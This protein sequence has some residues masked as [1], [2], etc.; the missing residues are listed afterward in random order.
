MIFAGLHIGHDANAT[1]FVDGKLAVSVEAERVLGEKHVIGIDAALVALRAA[2]AH[3]GISSDDIQ[4]ICL[5]DERIPPLSVEERYPEVKKRTHSPPFVIP[6]EAE[7]GGDGGVV[8]RIKNELGGIDVFVCCH[9]VA[10]AASALYMAGYDACDVF[11]YDGYGSCGASMGLRYAASGLA[12][13]EAF[14][15]R[16]MVGFKYSQ[17]GYF[18]DGIRKSGRIGD[19]NPAFVADY[20]DFAGKIMGAH[21]YGVARPDLVADFLD[22]FTSRDGDAYEKAVHGREASSPPIASLAPGNAYQNLCTDGLKIAERASFDV[23]AAMQEA[24]TAAAE[25]AVSELTRA[26]ASRRLVMAGG[27]AL[28]IVTNE[29]IARLPS[30]GELFIPPNCDDRGIS[31]GAAALLHSALTGTP[32]H[33]PDVS[34]LERRSPYKGSPL[35]HDRKDAGPGIRR[36]GLDP[37]EGASIELVATALLDGCTVGLVRGRS[38]IGPRALGNRSILAFPGDPE[39]KDRINR[40]IKHREWWRPFAPVVRSPDTGRFFDMPREDSY[41]LTGGLVRPGYRDSLAA[42]THVDGTARVQSLL[43]RDD[44]PVLWDLLTALDRRTGVGVLLNTS[45]NAGGKPLVSRASEAIGLLAATGLD[46]LWMDDVLYWKE[47][48]PA[49]AGLPPS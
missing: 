16:L 13:D 28:N 3:C 15:D 6:A 12:V 33:F 48:V 25:G 43:H 7:P 34:P 39:M 44:H 18:F 2:M 35:I 42:I 38:E 21:A 4:S 10:H 17:F 11:V 45:F 40:T 30:V 32:L 24:F 47:T 14:H 5:G 23:I 46:A 41:M 29:R 22:W 26:S 49:F 8:G 19:G 1:L 37:E 36:A 20:I 27:C 31:A 9:G